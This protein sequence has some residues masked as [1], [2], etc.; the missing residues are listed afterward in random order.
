[1]WCSRVGPI[2]LTVL[3]AACSPGTDRHPVEAAKQPPAAPEP[4]KS[5]GD[6]TI[7]TDDA[8]CRSYGLTYGTG[9]YAQCRAALQRQMITRLLRL[10][11]KT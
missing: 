11:P 6:D 4:A 2:A 5:V 7:Q 9:D 1:M 10:R 3:L 8:K